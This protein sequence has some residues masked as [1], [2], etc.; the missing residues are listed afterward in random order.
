MKIQ[1]ILVAL[2]AIL[3]LTAISKADTVAVETHRV[4]LFGAV[5]HSVKVKHK[6]RSSRIPT[7]ASYRR[8]SAPRIQFGFSLG[9]RGGQCNR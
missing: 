2:A 8:Y 5:H 6:R 7:T 3:W 1:P 4:G 9:C